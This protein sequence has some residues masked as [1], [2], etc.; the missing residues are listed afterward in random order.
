LQCSPVISCECFSNGSWGCLIAA[1]LQCGSGSGSGGSMMF[2]FQSEFVDEPAAAVA[3]AVPDGL[4]WGDRCDP[5]D[6]LPQEPPIKNG[7]DT[8]DGEG[9]GDALEGRLIGECPEDG[10]NFGTCSDTYVSNLICEYDHIYTG[11]SWD[12]LGCNSV[13]E[14]ECNQFDDGDWACLSFSM[15]GCDERT[16]PTDLPW[17][18]SCNPNDDLPLPEPDQQQ[19][20]ASS[21]MRDIP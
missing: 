17:G 14:C 6:D 16:T 13:M 9:D 21:F 20:P 5:N 2:E 4:P 3:A 1:Q 8:V 10:P 15:M 18:Q 12:E 11:C 19:Q 7:T